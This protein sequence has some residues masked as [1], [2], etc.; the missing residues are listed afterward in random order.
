MNGSSHTALMATSHSY[1]I[2]RLTAVH[3]HLGNAMLRNIT[4]YC[5]LLF[6]MCNDAVNQRIKCGFVHELNISHLYQASK[7]ATW[8]KNRKH[9]NTQT[10]RTLHGNDKKMF[11]KNNTTLHCTVS[12]K[13]T[14]PRRVTSTA[15]AAKTRI[16]SRGNL[17]H[18]ALFTITSVSALSRF[19]LNNCNEK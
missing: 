6:L 17:P 1:F 15:H 18:N 7:A 3:W 12:T 19:S 8:Q 2:G 16:V 10:T 5:Y 11:N 9:A 14:L 4:L 13:K